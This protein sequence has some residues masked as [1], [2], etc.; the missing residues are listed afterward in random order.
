LRASYVWTTIAAALLAGCADAERRPDTAGSGDSVSVI[1]DAGQVVR[2]DSAATRV[3]SLVPSVT[4]VVLALGLEHRLIARTEYD[5]HPRLDSLPS[6]G[7]GLTPNIEWLASRSPDLVI[8]WRDVEGRALVERLAELGIPVYASRL[9]DVTTALTTITRIG[10]L[11]GEP[12]RADSLRRAMETRFDSVRSASRSAPR[13]SVLYLV[14]GD[15]PYAPGPGTFIDELIEIAGGTNALAD[16]PEG[17]H[18]ISTE[19]IVRRDPDL[20]VLPVHPGEAGVVGALS[21]RA[22]WRDLRA[23]RDGQVHEVDGQ[24]FGRPGPQLDRAAVALAALLGRAGARAR[25]RGAL[26]PDTSSGTGGLR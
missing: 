2:L 15:P 7:P 3:V 18:S 24:L 23:V 1:D 9:E 19:E 12:A 21:R 16:L 5:L 13:A 20:I 17:W 6:V 14:G 10:V 25:A 26:P 22:G 11:L 4:D 8:A